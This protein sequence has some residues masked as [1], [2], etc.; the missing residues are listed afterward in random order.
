MRQRLDPGEAE[1]IALA[2]EIR[3]DALLIDETRG[4]VVERRLGLPLIGVLALL[5]RAKRTSMITAVRPLM[6]L[7][8]SDP[9]PLARHAAAVALRK[10]A[11][12]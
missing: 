10:L 12:R 4:R 11:P 9:S 2:L 8:A 5:V 6:D 1:A 3:P 7:K